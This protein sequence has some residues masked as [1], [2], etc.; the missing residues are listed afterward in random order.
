M[1]K[2][3]SF[4]DEVKQIEKEVKEIEPV[5]NV[6]IT[7]EIREHLNQFYHDVCTSAKGQTYTSYLTPNV[8][9]NVDGKRVSELK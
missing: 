1:V 9:V 5:E 7:E 8:R 4:V 6:A 3:N 2:S